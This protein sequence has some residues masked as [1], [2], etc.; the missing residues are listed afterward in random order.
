MWQEMERRRV[1]RREA[2]QI[3]P[4]VILSHYAQA[5][6][7]RDAAAPVLVELGYY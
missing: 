5:E 3:D 7:D 1:Q 4:C 2:R 6:L